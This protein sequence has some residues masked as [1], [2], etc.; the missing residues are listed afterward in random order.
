MSR[1]P[2]EQQ[3]LLLLE[4]VAL[5]TLCIR[6][7]WAGLH[8]VYSYFFGYLVL[9]FLQCLIP[10]V[11]PIRSYLYRNLF[12]ASQ[13]LIVVF[14]ALVVLELYAKALRDLAGIASIARRFIRVTLVLSF[15]IAVL[16]FWWEKGTATMTGYFFTF[17]RTVVSALVVFVLLISG[18]LVYYP[19][20]LGRNVVVYLAGY[21]VFFLAAS[22]ASFIVN[23]GY[24][25][26]RLLSSFQM[27][28]AVLCLL[29]WVLTLNRKGEARQVVV[30][31]QWNPADE[32]RLLSQLEAINASLLRS[33]RK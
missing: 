11:V 1:L 16:P 20:P 26:A 30:G 19:V 10:V 24:F 13:G 8:K 6:L 9:E 4:I 27:V 22:T 5:L 31:H 33:G 7:W 21:T 14:Y 28:V 18:F 29:F 25:W 3:V 23:L 12:V 32:L 15:L 17:E 2:I